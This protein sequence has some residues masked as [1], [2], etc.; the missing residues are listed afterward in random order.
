MEKN[1]KHAKGTCSYQCTTFQVFQFLTTLFEIDGIL[2]VDCFMKA[3]Q[4]PGCRMSSKYQF[5][6]GMFDFIYLM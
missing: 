2:D 5:C 6:A 3:L 4:P 1:Q